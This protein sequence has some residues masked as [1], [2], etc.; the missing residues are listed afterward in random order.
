[1]QD[2]TPLYV[3]LPKQEAERLDR[4]AFELKTSKQD[5]VA[6]LV[7]AYGDLDTLR[8]VT[9]ET[10]DDSLAIGHAAFRPFSPPDVLTVA[11]L[12]SWLQVDEAAVQEL[13][14]QGELPGRKLAGDWRFAREAVLDWLARRQ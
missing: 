1:M 14:E 12:A 8:R 5:L 4:A 13:A 6:G 2:R 11:E 3:R 9:V 7:A 10:L